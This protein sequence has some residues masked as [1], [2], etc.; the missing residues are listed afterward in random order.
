MASDGSVATFSA[1]L[2][3]N[4]R[5]PI[6]LAN[7]D[8]VTFFRPEF[9]RIKTL[10]LTLVSAPSETLATALQPCRTKPLATAND[11]KLTADSIPLLEILT[12]PPT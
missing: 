5:S 12:V 11:A 6:T 3:L 8:S 2:V 9:E 10:P 1:T 7:I 4:C